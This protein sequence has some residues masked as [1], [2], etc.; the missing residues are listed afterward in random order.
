M[1]EAQQRPEDANTTREIEERKNR[2]NFKDQAEEN[3]RE[4]ER[5]EEKKK[6]KKQ[7]G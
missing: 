5:L 6:E 4:T 7:Q 1:L 2:H 3:R